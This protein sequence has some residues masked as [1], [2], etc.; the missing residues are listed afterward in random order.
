MNAST[1]TALLLTA[2]SAKAS[3][4][5]QSSRNISTPW[6]GKKGA[7]AEAAAADAALSPLCTGSAVLLLWFA[8]SK[9]LHAQQVGKSSC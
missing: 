4:S 3:W 5:V 2:V 9:P 1:A 8:S 7:A 6:Q